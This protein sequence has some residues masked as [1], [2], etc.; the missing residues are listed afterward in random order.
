MCINVTVPRRWLSSRIEGCVGYVGDVGK[1][2]GGVANRSHRL[3][4]RRCQHRFNTSKP[5]RLAILCFTIFT[6]QRPGACTQHNWEHCGDNWNETPTSKAY[7]DKQ[8]R[9]C[10]WTS[11]MELYAGKR[12]CEVG[13]RSMTKPL[14]AWL[15]AT[16]N[17][18]T[19]LS[20][21]R[22]K[23]R[24]RECRA[25]KRVSHRNSRNTPAIENAYKH[26]YVNSSL[27]KG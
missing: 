5:N 18:G 14:F 22:W 4:G 15:A 19:T 8:G 20:F 12:W 24:I 2:K 23:R 26:L 16:R 6:H 25:R 13:S 17:P 21:M 1:K 27:S 3:P 10:Y 11:D 9:V 7:F